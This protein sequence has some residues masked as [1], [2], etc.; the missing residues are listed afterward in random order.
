MTIITQEVPIII[1]KFKY[2]D[3]I[4]DT[5]LNSINS[6]SYAKISYDDSLITKSD[7]ELEDNCCCEYK[8]LLKAPMLLHCLEQMQQL[9]YTSIVF[10]NFWFQQY[11]K[12]AIH[13]WHIHGEAQWTNVYYLELPEDAPKTEFI[14]P[15]TRE[16]KTFSVKEG[17]VLTFPSF[18]VHRAPTVTSDSRKTI[19]SFNSCTGVS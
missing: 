3:Q 7:W 2:H 15:I 14:D 16:I 17:D 18:I 1:S 13:N 4:K 11:E 12:D 5:I 8:G 9:G 19:I 10:H 6:N